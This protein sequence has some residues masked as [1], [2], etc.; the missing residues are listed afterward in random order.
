MRCRW[1]FGFLS[2][3]DI[4]PVVR[5]RRAGLAWVAQASRAAGLVGEEVLDL[6]VNAAQ[7]VVSPAA[8]G[9]EQPGVEAEEEAFGFSHR[10]TPV[11]YRASSC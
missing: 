8:D 5:V 10:G 3:V 9:I 2:V 7:V 11:R 4:R 6:G 1:R